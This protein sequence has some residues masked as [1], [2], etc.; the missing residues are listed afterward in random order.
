MDKKSYNEKYND[1][2]YKEESGEY[3]YR[4]PHAALTAD[5]VIFGF[6]G[7]TLKILLIERAIEPFKGMWALPGGFMKVAAHEGSD[8]DRTIEDT[9]RRE[10]KEETN[11]SGV[12]LQQF[13]VFSS[14]DRDPRER[15]VT[16]AFIAL[17]GPSNYQHT[18]Q[19]TMAGDDA[20]NALWW[21][22]DALPPLAF[23][24]AEIIK[25]AKEY[26]A[27]M[28]RIKPVAF[29]LL[30]ATFTLSDLQKVYEAI[31]HQTFDRRNFQRKA[32]QSGVLDEVPSSSIGLASCDCS[33]MEPGASYEEIS[34]CE[35]VSPRKRKKFFTFNRKKTESREDEEGNIKDLFNF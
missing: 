33:M 3:S 11:L 27:E 19:S 10:L 12:F 18:V 30:D 31:T 17:I 2:F 16:V 28:I 23:D 9:A 35:S 15:V 32:I 14:F 22:E 13:K 6:D 20:S 8:F 21:N 29:N 5:C 25:Q 34:H 7:K 4:Y 1:S 24:H 26:L